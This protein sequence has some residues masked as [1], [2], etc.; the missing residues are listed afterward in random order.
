[1]SLN[2]DIYNSITWPNLYSSAPDYD[3][4]NASVFIVYSDAAKDTYL[5][6][7]PECTNRVDIN[8]ITW[9]L[10][11]GPTMTME[12]LKN[13]TYGC[14][15]V[16]NLQM[17]G[18][19]VRA[20][21]SG[22]TPNKYVEMTP[23]RADR[24][25]QYRT[26]DHSEYFGCSLR[27]PDPT[28][29]VVETLDGEVIF[30]QTAQ[31]IARNVVCWVM[32]SDGTSSELLRIKGKPSTSTTNT[33]NGYCDTT[34]KVGT[35]ATVGAEDGVSLQEPLYYRV[36]TRNGQ[37][38]TGRTTFDDNPPNYYSH[39]ATVYDNNGDPL[40]VTTWEEKS[41]G[42]GVATY[43]TRSVMPGREALA[44]QVVAIYMGDRE[45]LR[46]TGLAQTEAWHRS[47]TKLTDFGIDHASYAWIEFGNRLNGATRT[48]NGNTVNTEY[49]LTR[50][51][52]GEHVF[53]NGEPGFKYILPTMPFWFRGRCERGTVIATEKGEST[54]LDF[55]MPYIWGYV[56]EIHEDH[57][58]M[59]PINDPTQITFNIYY[60]D[61]PTPET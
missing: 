4:A 61:A 5:Y 53:V 47:A 6:L 50:W 29:T 18:G 57:L 9:M 33:T 26:S 21:T 35:T 46:Y 19:R 36:H 31:E 20:R 60:D 16:I 28:A 34:P 17:I 1:M 51:G 59:Q 25:Q 45:W 14:Y 3:T 38:W 30:N 43:Q 32:N 40:F 27:R 11:H 41:E 13:G 58:V 56:T 7:D 2:I 49:K 8:D 55:D 52:Y 23:N 54:V 15:Y 12:K 39:H 48:V 42:A 22:D 10:L 37:E 24:A 44:D